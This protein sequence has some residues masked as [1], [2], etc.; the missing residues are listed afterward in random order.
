MDI[1]PWTMPGHISRSCCGLG[2]G[3]GSK[4]PESNQRSD[5]WNLSVWWLEV[6]WL[7]FFEDPLDIFFWQKIIFLGGSTSRNT[8]ETLSVGLCF[9]HHFYR[10]SCFVKGL[11]EFILGELSWKMLSVCLKL[12]SRP[13]PYIIFPVSVRQSKFSTVTYVPLVLDGLS[14]VSI[15]L[16][17][18]KLSDR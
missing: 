1:R 11:R 18:G 13:Q 9:L 3:L 8:F 7:F 14:F 17:E 2:L 15:K 10:F 4:P 6:T 16:S 5:D 12:P